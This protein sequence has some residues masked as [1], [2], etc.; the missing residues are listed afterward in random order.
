MS[1]IRIFSATPL[2]SDGSI[3]L[4]G[5]AARHLAKVLRLQPGDQVTLFDGHGLE[6]LSVINTVNKNSVTLNT[7]VG[8]QPKTES[9]LALEL[10]WTA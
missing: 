8:Q 4:T 9:P 5:N 1:S 6:Y 2:Q 10:A 7:G 3:E